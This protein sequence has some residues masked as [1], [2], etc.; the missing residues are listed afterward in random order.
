LLLA[1][2]HNYIRQV[3]GQDND[4]VVASE[5]AKYGEFQQ[6][7]WQCDHADMIGYNLDTA[8]VGPPIFPH[9]AK[10]DAIIAQL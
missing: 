7:T 1:P 8:G 3:T 2:T 10:I 6:P 9:L 4:G 5:S